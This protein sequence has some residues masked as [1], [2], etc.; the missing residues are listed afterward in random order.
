MTL[1]GNS[2]LAGFAVS[3]VGFGFFMYGKKQGRPPQILL[4]LISLVYPYF[5]SSPG[6]IFGIFALLLAAM[7]LA[8]R[9]GW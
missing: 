8:L 6:W 4:G 9:L 5:V 1:D 3:T 2:L 7:S